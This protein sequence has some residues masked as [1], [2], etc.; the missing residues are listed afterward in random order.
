MAEWLGNGLQNRLRRFE[1]GQ[2]LVEEAFTVV[3]VSLDK[4]TGKIVHIVSH[5]LFTTHQA[6]AKRD[7]LLAERAKRDKY[8]T[9]RLEVYTTKVLD[10]KNESPFVWGRTTY[11]KVAPKSPRVVRKGNELL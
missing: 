4:E 6:F 11:P 1:S 10:L 7:E 5:G 9:S 3:A 2:S 8:L